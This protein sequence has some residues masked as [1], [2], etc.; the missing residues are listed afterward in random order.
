MKVVRFLVVL[1]IF[2]LSGCATTE[3]VMRACK[4]HGGPNSVS[5]NSVRKYVVC[6]DHTYKVIR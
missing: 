5:G 2:V 1:C 4:N 6:A 3:D